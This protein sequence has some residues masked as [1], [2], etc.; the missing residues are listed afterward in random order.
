M[1]LNSGYFVRN[2]DSGSIVI[3]YRVYLGV[4][5]KKDM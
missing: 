1:Y 3:L 2:A 5:V 4:T